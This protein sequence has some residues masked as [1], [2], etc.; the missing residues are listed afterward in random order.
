MEA[1]DWREREVGFL[2]VI[3]LGPVSLSFDAAADSFPMQ[4][5][6]GQVALPGP[7]NSGGLKLIEI[8]EV[9][10]GA[11]DGPGMQSNR[12]IRIGLLTGPGVALSI[13]AFLQAPQ[14]GMISR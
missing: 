13:D 1:S 12:G 14:T 4:E 8:E 5:A 2:L 10:G 7:G 6:D 3:Q 11:F 9:L